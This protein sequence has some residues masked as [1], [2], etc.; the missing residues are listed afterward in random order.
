MKGHG[1]MQVAKA[2]GAELLGFWGAET[3]PPSLC[4]GAGFPPVPGLERGQ[5]MQPKAFQAV[6][7]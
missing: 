1:A 2:A 7:E 5:T 6:D 3:W 4:T